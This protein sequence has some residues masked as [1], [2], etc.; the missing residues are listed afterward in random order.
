MLMKF[1]VQQT[2][3]HSKGLRIVTADL[4]S[5]KLLPKLVP[6]TKLDKNLQICFTFTILL[7]LMN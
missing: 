4:L 1:A 6:K 2:S 5:V 7:H 3:I